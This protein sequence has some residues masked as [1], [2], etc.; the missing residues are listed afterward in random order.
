MALVANTWAGLSSHAARVGAKFPELVAA[1]W[2]LKA[3]LASI[4][5]LKTIHLA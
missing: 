1:Q 5:P 2:G 4:L 3:I